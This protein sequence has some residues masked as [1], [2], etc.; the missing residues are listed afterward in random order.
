MIFSKK[1]TKRFISEVVVLSVIF[2]FGA[3]VVGEIVA[4]VYFNP[5]RPDEAQSLN[6]NLPVRVPELRR[7]TRFLGIE[8]DFQVEQALSQSSLTVVGLYRKKTGDNALS[9]LY[10]PSELLGSGVILTS[11]GWLITSQS[12]L[13]SVATERVAVIYRNQ[14]FA[15]E[16]VVADQITGLVFLKIATKNLPVIILGDSDENMLGQL[17]VTINALGEATVPIIEKPD[18]QPVDQSADFVLSS[19]TYADRL[20]LAGDLPVSYLG[21]P[22]LNLAGEVTGIISAVDATGNTVTAVPINQ[23]RSVILSLLKNKKL[24]RPYLGVSYLDLAH[25]PGLTSAVA[26]HASQGALVYRSP[27]RH[28]PAA[29]AGLQVNDIILSVDGQAVDATNNLTKLIQQ[30]QPGDVISLVV[31]RGEKQLDLTVTLSTLSK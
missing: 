9:Q 29:D 19:E 2:G 28:S 23:F 22:V 1:D 11:D 25:A 8:Q 14:Q 10:T 13:G 26:A 3:G 31:V 27:L 16:Q 4:N 21:A 6:A 15:I 12:V 17:A 30:N 5:F 20:L 24:T 7:T 18:F